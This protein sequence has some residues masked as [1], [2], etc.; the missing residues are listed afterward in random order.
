M[1]SVATYRLY[2]GNKAEELSSKAFFSDNNEEVLFKLRHAIQRNEKQFYCGFCGKE[3][4]I[5]GGEGRNKQRLHF[6]HKYK[7]LR[8]YCKYTDEDTETRRQIERKK[9]ANKEEGELHRTI[10]FTIANSLETHYGADIRIE[11]Y[12]KDQQNPRDH[13][14]PDIRAIF[15][16]KDVVVEVQITS[17]F[18]DVILGRQDFY[19]EHNMYL[20]WVVNEFKPE[21]FHQKDIL[22]SSKENNVFVFD[23][24]ARE[25]TEEEGILYLKCYHKSYY[26]NINGDIVLSPGFACELITFDDLIFNPTD[27]SVFYFDIDENKKQCEA[28]Q[29]VIKE[30]IRKEAEQR[31]KQLEAIRVQQENEE[32]ERQRLWQIEQEKQREEEEKRQ[33]EAEK[34]REKED[35]ERKERERLNNIRWKQQ[36][37]IEDYAYRASISLDDYWLYYQQLNDEERRFADEEIHNIILKSI[38]H[39]YAF[40][41]NKYKYDKNIKDLY[42]FLLN[43]KYPYDWEQF[44]N[45][46]KAYFE[47]P[48]YELN[49]PLYEYITL[50]LYVNHNY[51]LPE[52]D[53]E[54]FLSKITQR[55]KEIIEESK[56]REKDYDYA[57]KFK[58]IE[59]I[60][61]SYE[62]VYDSPFREDKDRYKL[63][64][65]K[66]DIIRHL[67][68]IY[69]GELVGIEFDRERHYLPFRDK[70]ASPY[71]HLY[72][73]LIQHRNMIFHNHGLVPDLVRSLTEIEKKISLQGI[74]PNYDLDALM[75][76][77]FPD[78]QWALQQTLF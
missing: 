68:S 37:K 71:Y 54:K 43:N 66:R 61:W 76:I 32:K 70:L 51:H 39:H 30:R 72:K 67:F 40:Y 57:A 62:R 10:K 4:T 58:D 65:Y 73:T 45:I 23:G 36:R 41:E 42:Y 9:F 27:Y 33:R 74:S 14:I 75:P 35:A 50:N 31:R 28:E 12:I 19:V 48:Y 29:Q 13:R 34:K 5:R 1:Y 77:I 24:E 53:K 8:D 16:D 64:Y 7:K 49:M 78:I 69:L 11:Q 46:P 52:K 6:R 22:Y 18:L 60:I 44:M 3:L 38:Y 20:L 56:S 63:I 17:T 26:C 59:M 15:P 47:R 25:R 55:F 21:L 2:T